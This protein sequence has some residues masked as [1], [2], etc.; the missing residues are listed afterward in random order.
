MFFQ[1]LLAAAGAAQ[2]AGKIW[3][4]ENFC[5]DRGSSQQFKRQLLSSSCL[6]T[7]F[8]A[9]PV[10]LLL[11]SP[12]PA[13]TSLGNSSSTVNLNGAGSNPF[14]IASNITVD[15]ALNTAIYGDGTHA[16]TL[17]NAGTVRSGGAEGVD[18]KSANGTLTNLGGALIYGAANGAEL[19]TGAS[20]ANS[21]TIECA[22]SDGGSYGI[23]LDGTGTITNHA[24]GTI[25]GYDAGIQALGSA[26]IGNAGLIT[27]G[28][29][30]GGAVN[31]T[32]DGTVNNLSTGTIV[33]VSDGIDISGGSGFINN[34]GKVT[35]GN[36]GITLRGSGSVL[37]SGLIT[38]SSDV[39]VLLA[40][41]GDQL[42]NSSTGTIQADTRGVWID[43]YA[44]GSVDNA[45]TIVSALAEAVYLNGGGTVSN[46]AGG[47]ISGYS[48]GVF[49]RYAT[50]DVQNAGTIVARSTA[51][52]TTP[53]GVD[54][55]H[56]GTVG[57]AMGGLIYGY[58][59]GVAISGAGTVDNAGSIGAGYA[60][61]VAIGS[62]YVLNQANARISGLGGVSITGNGS[63]MNSGEI[64]GTAVGA[65][66]G[67][68]SVTNAAS[69]HITGAAA[70]LTIADAGG[71]LV[72]AGSIIGTTMDGVLMH[73]GG[74][75]SNAAAGYIHGGGIGVAAGYVHNTAANALDLQNGGVISG[76]NTGVFFYGLDG[77]AVTNLAG[78]TITGGGVGVY[79]AGTNASITNSGLIEGNGFVGVFA[80]SGQIANAAGGTISGNYG[81]IL[82]Q[83]GSLTNSGHINGTQGGIFI[84]SGNVTNNAGAT[85]S[86]GNLG[87]YLYSAGDGLTNAGLVTAGA[88]DA[89]YSKYGATV[90]NQ[91]GGTLAGAISY[92]GIRIG[93]ANNALQNLG[94][95]QN[96]G[97]IDG[98]SGV[99]LY[100]LG[101]GT[102]TNL[103]SGSIT[104]GGFGVLIG[105][106][107]GSVANAGF[108]H[109]ESY[110]GVAINAGQISNASTG[111]ITGGGGVFINSA[112]TVI[113]SGLIAGGNG[114]RIAS[115]SVIN[116]A[117]G[118]ISGAHIGVYLTGSGDSLGN[119]GIVNGGGASGDIG[120]YLKYGG[121]VL[122][123]AGGTIGGDVGLQVGYDGNTGGNS[124]SVV[125]GGVILGGS[126][127]QGIALFGTLGGTIT[128]L[129]GGTI[130]SPKFGIL[131][132]IGTEAIDNSGLI[133]G[134]ANVGIVMG[135]GQLNNHAGGTITGDYGVVVIGSAGSIVNA[136][137]ISA[138]VT[139]A[140]V[141]TGSILNAGTGT[142]TGG[143]IGV[144]LYAGGDSLS[145]AG[146][147]NGGTASGD[148]GAYLKYGGS[149]LNQA[150]GHISGNIGVQ[151]GYR[152][153]S[154]S[155]TGLIDNQ[156]VIAG[157]SF[158]VALFNV[159]GGSIDNAAGATIS[160][161]VEGIYAAL[162][163]SS[164]SNSGTITGGSNG[165]DMAGGVLTNAA[166]A[167]IDG[168]GV[169]LLVN[170]SAQ[171]N[172]AGTI[173]DSAGA[174]AILAGAATLT[175]SGTVSGVTGL[176]LSGE[177]GAVINSG[178]IASTQAGGN[179]ILVTAPDPAQI[180]LTS[181]SVLTGA[182][183]GGGTD[184]QI[185]LQGS[186]QIG[187]NIVN[188]GTGSGLEIASGASWVATGNWTVANVT[189]NGIF[190][191]GVLGT[192][193][194]LTGDFTQAPAGTMQVIVTPTMSSQFIITGNATLAGGIKYVFA[195]GTY[196]AHV[197]DFLTATGTVTGNY[198]SVTYAGAAPTIFTRSTNTMPGNADFVLAGSGTQNTGPVVPVGGGPAGGGSPASGGSGP[199]S[200]GPQIIGVVAPEDG[201]LFS[202]EPQV[203]AALTQQDTGMLL[204]KAA[205]GAAAGSAA[206]AA[207]ADVSPMA[208]SPD[209]TPKAGV[210]ASIAARAVC[211]AGGWVAATGGVLN[212]D[213]SG[214][215]PSYAA[216]TAG[217]MAGI[218]RALSDAGTRLGLAVGYDQV[219]LH[220]DLQGKFSSGVTR[221]G[222][223]GS[224]PLGRFMLAGELSGGFANN[225]TT[226]QTGIGALQDT[227]AIDIFS[228]GLQA[229][230]NISLGP[231]LLSP[232]A[233]MRFATVGSGG[234]SETARGVLGAFAV[235]GNTPH[236]SSVQPYLSMQVS[237][238]FSTGNGIVVMPVASLGYQAELADRGQAT[239]VVTADG[240]QF[241][242]AHNSLD[243]N[244]AL[245]GLEISAGKAGWSIYANYAAHVAGNWTEQ[246]GEIGVQAKF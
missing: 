246:T 45:G 68:G 215:A 79:A 172:N 65:S 9:L 207:A 67:G 51:A 2:Q 98:G 23:L 62:G 115:G 239:N 217:F 46:A 56:G 196:A 222:V 77:G 111:T 90:V 201:S 28:V 212:A 1:L 94:I 122:N 129:A 55:T 89:V 7:A 233:G 54:L 159:D 213:A 199:A 228:G 20:V 24:G 240:T 114:A 40:V 59:D 104:G 218:D 117:T 80:A 29:A 63:L 124:G 183:D 236:Y 35:A 74:S 93:Y 245:L 147:I 180:T 162:A 223:Y 21:G 136:G 234:I 163:T 187:N 177:N 83:T 75:A 175:N 171:I 25:A 181:G 195:P 17:S 66:L 160:G 165:V 47:L 224:Q 166:G 184:G 26:A 188:F 43:G 52:E 191:P 227:N 219:N 64:A 216:N 142:I 231:I 33:G 81:V 148:I 5:G 173:R 119:A 73:L 85:I 15:V 194:M 112:G 151:N 203:L 16:W 32:A 155:G 6:L 92:D 156:G 193:L 91:A 149:V 170:G 41:A 39:G 113:N 146:I 70:G 137:L 135:S 78:G 206:C 134:D 140:Y 14:S 19:G 186:N 11:A 176:I 123:Q 154:F 179:A 131:A 105:N 221:V 205:Q 69:G 138:A 141:D 107:T 169:G 158:G 110:Y 97:S 50:G 157:G 133:E 38:S 198:T 121:S 12:A 53:I 127:G 185:V 22:T 145:N 242:T 101:G 102:L 220:D 214:G 61:G 57:N 44:G 235:S 168:G 76:G 143:H 164:I 10:G 130:A 96:S 72:N 13:Q 34:A 167:L 211:G 3:M 116:N 230:T 8:L 174:G 204:D 88:G 82:N 229:S 49:I 192:P 152:N 244:A 197:Y 18:L 31:L 226:R 95:V 48:Q 84:Y 144:Y 99:V 210:F 86:G 109:A 106:G 4:F 178:V 118:S 153:D 60:A 139:A 190:Q 209:G 37:N 108:I 161:G 202:A 42:T 200:S 182:I 100:G 27:D 71:S 150:G 126:T 189:N 132:P 87:V 232:E 30:D 208:T 241:A 103:A 125:N 225:T 58:R 238:P 237:R 243:G 128:N 120:A 36:Y